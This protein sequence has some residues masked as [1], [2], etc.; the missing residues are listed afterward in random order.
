MSKK[1]AELLDRLHN[2]KEASNNARCHILKNSHKGVN[3][4]QLEQLD[5]THDNYLRNI[6]K[7]GVKVKQLKRIISHL[8]QVRDGELSITCIWKNPFNFISENISLLSFKQCIKIAEY[9][10]IKVSD[11]TLVEKWIISLFHK[12]DSIYITHKKFVEEI[13]DA[14]VNRE[15]PSLTRSS[16]I[17][18]INK[19]KKKICVKERF[20]DE[21]YY[22]TKYYDELQ[23]KN[24]RLMFELF[25]VD[26]KPIE[27]SLSKSKINEHISFYENKYKIKFDENQKSSIFNLCNNK[28]SILTGYPGTGKSEIINCVCEYLET[29]NILVRLKLETDEDLCECEDHSDNDNSLGQNYDNN[30]NISLTAPTGLATN[31]LIERCHFK[32]KVANNVINTNLFRLLNVVFPKIIYSLEYDPNDYEDIESEIRYWY[33]QLSACINE[34]EK[35]IIQKQI[36]TLEFYKYKPNIIICDESSMINL[37]LFDKLLYY[38]NYF[39]CRLILVGDENQLPPIGGG[40]PFKD[41]ID[42]GIFSISNLTKIYRN[43]GGLQ[44][45]I[46]KMNF[47]IVTNSDIDNKTIKFIDI[48]SFI[49]HQGLNIPLLTKFIAINC[50]NK[51]NTKFITSQRDNLFGHNNLNKVLQRIFNPYGVTIDNLSNYSNYIN[52]RVDDHILRIVNNYDDSDGSCIANGD[53]AKIVGINS[54]YKYDKVMIKYDKADKLYELSVTE[55]QEEFNLSYGLSVHKAQGQGFDNVILFISKQHN[56]MWTNDNSK[57]LLYTAIS[58]AKKRCFIIGNYS[59]F[60]KAQKS[61][62][63]ENPSIFMKK[64]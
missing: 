51:D 17:E 45:C 5:E 31:N 48:E 40:F 46:K 49:K 12:N 4:N 9:Y 60:I 25:C 23:K 44:N 19:F 1:E 63:L 52:Y 18:L 41:I 54:N 22:T 32:N 20:N 37:E 11:E 43:T 26:K 6:V 62:N 10:K 56:Y 57:K 33:G 8:N 42:S 30:Y 50:L 3:L 2:I 47:N 15:L 55:L 13:N 35:K 34:K 38:C 7:L 29:E 61:L 58:R 59:L 27:Y 16:L 24:G 39:E 21:R 53:S 36:W 14:S 64:F 28:F